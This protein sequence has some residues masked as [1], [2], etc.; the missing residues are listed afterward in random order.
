MDFI[1]LFDTKPLFSVPYY[2][3]YIGIMSR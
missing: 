1:T 2:T 3:E